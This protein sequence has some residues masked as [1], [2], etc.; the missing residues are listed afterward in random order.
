MPALR[1]PRPIF[2]PLAHAARLALLGMA[3]AAGAAHATGPVPGEAAQTYQIAPGPLG[4]T[5]AGVATAGGISLS[6]DPAL[7]EGL[8]SPALSGQYSPQQALQRLLAG[9]GLD[10][11]ARA[12]GSFTLRRLPVA[13]GSAGALGEVR[14][15]AQAERSAITDGTGSYVASAVTIGKTTQRLREIP[16]SVSVLTQERIRDQGLSTVAEALQ[17]TVGLRNDSYEGSER[18]TAR[19]YSMGA[20]FDGLP[21]ASSLLYL[22]NDLALYDRIEVLRGPSGLLQG[23]GS[24][25]GSVNYVR[26]RPRDTA[27]VDLALAAGTWNNYRAEVDATGP[28]NADGS[29]RGR[30]V[31]AYQDQDRFYAVG[32]ARNAVAYGTLEYDLTPD[33][34]VGLALT[35][36]DVER[37]NFFGLPMYSNGELIRD[38]KAFVG[39][40]APATQKL[41]EIAIDVEHR[42]G[43]GWVARGAA[44]RK[45]MA[46][47]GYGGYAQGGVDPAT[48]RVGISVGRIQTDEKWSGL[49]IGMSG[50]VQMFG[51]THSLS[52]GYN[53]ISND[54]R[55]NT[56][57]VSFAD[58]DVLNQHDFGD[59]LPGRGA[60]TSNNRINETGLYGVA[61]IKLADPLTLVAGGRWTRYDKKTRSITAAGASDWTEDSRVHGEFTPYGGVVWDFAPQLTWYASYAD[62]F[63]PQ[64]ARDYTGKLLEPRVGWQVETG[65]KGEFLDG[66]L[67][68]SLA[69]F[70]IR[71]NNRSM[72]DPDPSH[73]CADS[74]DG[75]C[76]M[77][78]GLVQS[79]GWEL[80]V[81]GRPAP[82]WNVSAGYTYLDAKFLRDDANAGKRFATDTSPRHMLKLW[83]HHRF[84]DKALGG[85]LAGWSLGVGLQAQSDIDIQGGVRQGGYA[86]ASA[87]VGYRINRQWS[88]QLALNNL[89]DKTYRQSVGGRTFHNMYGAPRNAM[90]T[91]RG[92]F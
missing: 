19:G 49:D 85:A 72:L 20:Q 16:Q 44:S 61:R 28:L 10:M 43:N 1:D 23:S 88:A 62:I 87:V 75:S 69:L 74:W 34:K 51:R 38:R 4:R 24:P 39:P 9:S 52:F 67:N 33:T 37:V 71:D 18:I 5:L 54:Y 13:A 63:A 25:A 86:T 64:T 57:Y 48:G 12:D 47:T 60:R 68:A 30:A 65:V 40:D 56:N 81:V 7:T 45:T 26:K 77:A 78:A 11:V 83:S 79:Q 36:L 32:R 17:N 66:R 73:V 22:H 59:A 35:R 29:L 3:L 76:S 84:D 55:G 2:H 82:G 58:W 70:R 14:V 46:Y 53:R 21:Q 27:G 6:F 31:L 90:L 42:L 41:D 80:E 89:T 92:S 8:T 50:P 15:S 91:V